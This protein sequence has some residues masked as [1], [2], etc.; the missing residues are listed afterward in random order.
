VLFAYNPDPAFT[1]L[2]QELTDVLGTL[3]LSLQVAISH[4]FAPFTLDSDPTVP[5]VLSDLQQSS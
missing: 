2:L 1:L 3:A 5:T 4:A